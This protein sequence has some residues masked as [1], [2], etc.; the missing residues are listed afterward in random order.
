M[1]V[2]GAS[3]C[4][5][6][7]PGQNIDSQARLNPEA[8]KGLDSAFTSAYSWHCIRCTTI[9]QQNV[10]KRQNSRTAKLTWMWKEMF[11]IRDKAEGSH[12]RIC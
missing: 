4:Q 1:F 9:K 7:S 5:M 11:G 12:R 2:T 10:K 3:E 6:I 8:G